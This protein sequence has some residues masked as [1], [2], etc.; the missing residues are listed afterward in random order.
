MKTYLAKNAKVKAT[1]R[2]L[3]SRDSEMVGFY[4]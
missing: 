1:L 2:F 4:K 3:Q